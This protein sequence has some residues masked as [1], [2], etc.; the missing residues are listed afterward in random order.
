[1]H[2]LN[3][4]CTRPF[5]FSELEYLNVTFFNWPIGL[6]FPIARRLAMKLSRANP[7]LL[8]MN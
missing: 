3:T 2:R 6:R 5:V 1:M 7:S 8:E 4:G